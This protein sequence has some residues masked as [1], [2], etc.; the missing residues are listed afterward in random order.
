MKRK[1]I[2]GAV[3]LLIS[4]FFRINIPASAAATS[5]SI[6]NAGFEDPFLK[7]KDDF[8]IETPS[9]WTL[10]N[11]DGLIPKN[12]TKWTSNMGVGNTAPNSSFYDHKTPEGRN[13]GYVYLAQEPGSGI[14]GLF[15]TTDAV[16]EPDTKYTLKVDLGN[17]GGTFEGISLAGYPGYRVELLAG[18]TVM[19]ADHNNLYI[20]DGTFGTSTVT[21]TATPDSPYLGQKLGIRL[22]NLLQ[23]SF[24]G[25]DF[26]NVRLTAQPAY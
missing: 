13:I 4:I 14:G 10:Y 12:P 24:A 18:D 8:T 9:D 1:L 21:F 15:Q 22:I 3:V 20:K 11:P 7:I 17:I 16:L 26:D 19:A 23:G 2:I 6:K 25:T 5:I